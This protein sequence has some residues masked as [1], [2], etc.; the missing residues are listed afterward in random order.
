M[1]KQVTQVEL[2]CGDTHR[3]CWIDGS[4]PYGTKID[5]KGDPRIW[6]MIKVYQT[7]EIESINR[8]WTNNI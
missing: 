5:L 7:T 6:T 8:G 3:V 4:Y 2:I 1:S